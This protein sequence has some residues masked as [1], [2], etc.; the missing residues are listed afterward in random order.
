MKYFFIFYLRLLIYFIINYCYIVFFVL[1]IE[2]INFDS[3]GFEY[4]LCM[5]YVYRKFICCFV[6][7][8]DDEI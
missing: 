1:V 3:Y 5:C 8:V 2:M 6:F 7:Y 4:R